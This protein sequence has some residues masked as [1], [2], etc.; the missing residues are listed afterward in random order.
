MV[1]ELLVSSQFFFRAL[2]GNAIAEIANDG[3]MGLRSLRSTVLQASK[4]QQSKPWCDH[5][6]TTVAPYGILTKKVMWQ[7]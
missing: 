1:N 5:R 6:W 3:F 2:N 4:R 7:H